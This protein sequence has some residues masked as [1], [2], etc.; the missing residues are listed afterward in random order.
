M[1]LRNL[2]KNP[3]EYVIE[4]VSQIEFK[5]K[6]ILYPDGDERP[7]LGERVTFEIKDENANP[8]FRG[9]G[10]MEGLGISHGKTNVIDSFIRGG[11]ETAF[12]RRA[13]DVDRIGKFLLTTQGKQFL[14]TQA[15]LQLLNPYP[16][17]IYNL[18]VNTL[19]SVAA[20]GVLNIKRGGLLPFDIPGAKDDYLSIVGG[21]N[22][23]FLREINYGLGDPG[24]P[25]EGNMLDKLIGDLNPFK[26]NPKKDYTITNITSV[27]KTN[28]LKILNITPENSG[29]F[30]DHSNNND[31]I[32]FR[33]EVHNP[34]APGRIGNKIIV[35]RAFLDSI[36]DDY[37][38]NHNTY[39]YNGRGEEFFTYNKFARKLQVSFKIAAQTRVE[40]F[41]LYQKLNYLVAQTAPNY[42]STGRIRTPWMYLTVGDWFRR[43]P[44]LLTSVNLSWQKDYPW[45]IGLKKNESSPRQQSHIDE[46]TKII[47]KNLSE[48][49]TSTAIDKM[50]DKVAKRN[51][52]TYETT[53]SSIQIMPHVL[54]VS[55]NFQP[56]HSF[57]PNNTG[58][59]S[60]IARTNSITNGLVILDT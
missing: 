52:N 32:P 35:F 55:I 56:I 12:N 48:E 47:S 31:F 29:E 27:D 22:K 13:I 4:G 45:E 19:A 44:G 3:E 49:D 23:K 8:T 26:K 10:G 58:Y 17:K 18:G 9:I 54:D 5:Q 1:G 57:T 50:Q 6:S 16:Q 33:F 46:V 2:L 42:S 43:I 15:A 38:A 7:L 21:E 40:M 28:A 53:D 34:D 11:A 39:K 25:S 30:K 20:A 41:P 36:S 37:S 59:N 51:A 24:K 14:A 60:F